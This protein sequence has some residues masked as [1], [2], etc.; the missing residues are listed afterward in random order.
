MT[1]RY[2]IF[3]TES[4]DEDGLKIRMHGNP[5]LAKSQKEAIKMHILRR[6]DREINPEKVEQTNGMEGMHYL[7]I[8]V[9]ETQWFGHPENP[10]IHEILGR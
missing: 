2:Q 9:S 10:A 5:I 6:D 7:A 8:P 1:E 4:S 3:E